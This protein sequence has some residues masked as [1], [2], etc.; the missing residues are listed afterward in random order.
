MPND[1]HLFLESDTRT[2][3]V[4]CEDYHCVE[5]KEKGK[6]FAFI[7]GMYNEIQLAWE[8]KGDI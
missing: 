6:S 2:V 8:I 5:I 7:A 4:K 1:T 3:K